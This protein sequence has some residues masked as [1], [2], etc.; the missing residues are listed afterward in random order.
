MSKKFPVLLKGRFQFREKKPL[1][2]SKVS[3][4]EKK[5]KKK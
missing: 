2:N 3:Q 5:V 4:F 1:K